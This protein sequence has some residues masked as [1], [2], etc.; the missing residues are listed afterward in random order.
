MRG[1]IRRTMVDQGTIDES[2]LSLACPAATPEEAVRLVR[3]GHRT[4]P[5]GAPRPT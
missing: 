4:E 5:K 3:E 2:D 1:F